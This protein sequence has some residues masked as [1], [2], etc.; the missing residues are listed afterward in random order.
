MTD[1]NLSKV[2][3]LLSA[4]IPGIALADV[5]VESLFY[6]HEAGDY[7]AALAIID[8]SGRAQSELAAEVTER[9]YLESEGDLERFTLILAGE[10]PMTTP[11]S[12]AEALALA[13]IGVTVE[14]APQARAGRTWEGNGGRTWEGNGGRTWEGSSAAAATGVDI[15][16][17]FKAIQAG[18]H[19]GA[20]GAIKKQ[21]G[22][23]ESEAAARVTERVYL[24]ANGDLNR[25]ALIMSGE[26]PMDTPMTD[27][28]AE[29]LSGQGIS[30]RGNWQG[31][32]GRTWEGNGGRT[33]E[34]SSSAAARPVDIEQL[35]HAIGAGDH[36]GA[37]DV[38][39]ASTNP[40]QSEVAATV[41]ERI[42]RQANGDLNRFSLILAGD[43]PMTQ[44]LTDYEARVLSDRGISAQGTWKGN[45]GRTW[46]GNGG[47]T[48][49]GS[50]S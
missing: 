1:K 15:E 2:A 48:W 30:A 7:D 23:E 24:Q 8:S 33:W 47:R 21:F 9:I 12:D 45:G 37:V 29:V 38:I 22:A 31:N 19:D 41:T 49:E 20:V 6:A 14:T 16:Q 11:L 25:F 4:A 28:E 36:L 34:G 43:E 44:P 26:E 27:Y 46:E 5:D 18:D 50:S 17:L 40:E 35:F 13:D 39:R 3:F 10:A 42:F 32:G